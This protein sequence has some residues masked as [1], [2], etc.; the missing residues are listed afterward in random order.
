MDGG[1]STI[2]RLSRI[3]P[4]THSSVSNF[5]TT[6]NTW[7]KTFV[8]KLH[9]RS[10]HVCTNSTSLNLEWLQTDYSR[11]TASITMAYLTAN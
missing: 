5:R 6:A 9:Y 8:L 11:I 10:E 7:A 3:V 4:S 1:S 2:S